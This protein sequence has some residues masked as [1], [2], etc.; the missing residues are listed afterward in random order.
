MGTDLYVC[1]ISNYPDGYDPDHDIWHLSSNKLSLLRD[2]ELYGVI[3]ALNVKELPAN[4]KFDRYTDDGIETVATD[5]WGVKLTFVDAREFKKIK[6]EKFNSSKWN[7][8]VLKFLASL[9]PKTP[10]VLYWH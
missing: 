3:K 7:V 1:P 2:Y 9:P 5:S 8:A 4:V 6:T 10:V